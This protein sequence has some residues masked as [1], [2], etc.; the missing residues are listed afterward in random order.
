M[1]YVPYY[2]LQDSVCQ[3]VFSW[4]INSSQTFIADNRAARLANICTKATNNPIPY[5]HYHII[6]TQILVRRVDGFIQVSMIILS[7][8]TVISNKIQIVCIVLTT[9][10]SH[11]LTSFTM[12]EIGGK[13]TWKMVASTLIPC[14]FLLWYCK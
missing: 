7:L 5:Q 1:I 2:N 3:L 9:L 10:S 12:I 6:S 14:S 8:F 11:R 13:K 4:V